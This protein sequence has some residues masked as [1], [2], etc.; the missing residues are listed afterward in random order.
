MAWRALILRGIIGPV[1]FLMSVLHYSSPNAL[2]KWLACDNRLSMETGR[3][4]P[5]KRPRL[6]GVVEKNS[7]LQVVDN[8]TSSACRPVHKDADEDDDDFIIPPRNGNSITRYFAPAEKNFSGTKKNG[9]LDKVTVKADVH[10]SPEE[11]E[12]KKVI[13]GAVVT[14]TKV[15]ARKK[16]NRRSGISGKQAD[17]IEVVSSEELEQVPAAQPATKEVWKVK[18][19]DDFQESSE[20]EVHSILI[21]FTFQNL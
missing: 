19:I 12:F 17:L 4:A 3:P 6:R 20:G 1:A 13:K 18:I 11:K 7:R 10:D 2:D 5:K 9:G 16:R 21:T 15:Q 8:E 14:T